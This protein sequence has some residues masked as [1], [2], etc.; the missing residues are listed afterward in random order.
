M[1][2]LAFILDK[3]DSYNSFYLM[4]VGWILGIVSALSNIF[5]ADKINL[6]KKLFIL[7]ILS[8]LVWIIPIFLFTYFGIPC[9]LVFLFIS[10]YVHLNSNKKILN[11]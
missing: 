1:M 3:G 2:T 8:S 6:N 9:L 4:L 7:F 5:L 10:I 11:G